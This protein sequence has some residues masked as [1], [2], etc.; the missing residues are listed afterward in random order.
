MKWFDMRYEM[1]NYIRWV[2][3][4]VYKYGMIFDIIYRKRKKNYGSPV[5]DFFDF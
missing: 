2:F 5:L 3:K 4:W 1:I